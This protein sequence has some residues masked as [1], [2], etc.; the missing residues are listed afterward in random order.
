MKKSLLISMAG[1]MLASSSFA[2]GITAPEA[3]KY[4]RIRHASGL[5]LTDIAFNAK[6]AED[7]PTDYSQ[8]VRFIPVQ[9][10]ENTY[11]I[12]R[13]KRGQFYGSDWGWSSTILSRNTSL[14]QFVIEPSTLGDGYVTFRNVGLNYVNKNKAC[15]GTDDVTK[16]NNVY[17]DKAGTDASKHI[18]MIEECN[19]PEYKEELGADVYPDK[20]IS[21]NDPRNVYPGYKLVFA[22]EF[23]GTGKPKS[24]IWNFETGFC[25]NQEHQYY[26]G[27][28]NCYLQDGVLVIE[29]RDILDEQRKN[30]KYVKG[31]TSWPSNIGQYLHWTSG[32]MTTK[33]SWN[34]GYSWKY[35]IYEVRAKVPQMVGCWPAIWSTGCAQEWPYGGEIDILEYYGGGIHANVAWGNGA[36]WGA[37]WNSQFIGD[38]KL[39]KGWGDE[40]HIWRMVWDYDHMELWC[41]DTIVNNINLDQTQNKVPGESFDHGNGNNPFRDV[42]QMLWLNLAI[43]GQNGGNPSAPPYPNRFLVDYARVYQKIGT[44]G[45]ATY[46]VDEEVSEPEFAIADG[47]YNHAV[48]SAV[49]D[50]AFGNTD[51]PSPVYYN[52]QGLEIQQPQAG[53][54]VICRRGDKVEKQIFK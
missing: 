29:A 14:S 6:V 10:M 19:L 2:D 30:P 50:I 27:N 28:R 12:E 45:R 26:D 3:G 15:L 9:G 4:Y 39:G 54:I 46:H 17:T 21:E 11:N 35:G 41:D 25:R 13:V 52:L 33:S 22:E 42:R 34:G 47:E 49:E 36:R 8:V 31:N 20:N 16:D 24:T 1:L 48:W 40:Y 43:G 32:S 18:W 51:T 37:S 23:G 7:D 44:D 38:D 5:Y 53:S